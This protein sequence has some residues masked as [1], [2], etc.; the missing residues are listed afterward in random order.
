MIRFAT[1]RRTVG[2]VYTPDVDSLLRRYFSGFVDF[3]FDFDFDSEGADDVLDIRLADDGTYT[4]HHK[5]L[6]LW[7]ELTHASGLP[8]EEALQ[9]FGEFLSTEAERIAGAVKAEISMDAAN[10]AA[11]ASAAS[12]K[13]PEK[14]LQ[15]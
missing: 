2:V 8:I 12:V 13:T 14:E 6:M 9:H 5:D 1:N 3:D 4:L 15:T 11:Q 7:G 10:H